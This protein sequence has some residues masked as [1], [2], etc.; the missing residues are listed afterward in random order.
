MDALRLFLFDDRRARRWAPFTLTRPVGE[1]RHGCLRLRERAEKA[2]GVACEGHVTRHALRGFDE[3]G[4]APTVALEE[5]DTDGTRVLL[6]SRVALELGSLEVGD[7][8]RRLTVSG[9]GAGWVVPAGEPPPSELWLRDPSS[10]P[11]EP[12]EEFQLEGTVLDRPWDLIAANPDR[13]ASDVGFLWSSEDDP[14]GVVRIGDG[15]ISL[16]AGATVEPGVHVDTRGG[17]V[18]LDEGVRVEG[19]ARL[20]GPLFVG[21]HSRILG[22]SVGT[23]S[24]GPVCIVRG[25][26]ADSVIDGFVNK[27]HDGYLGHA[28][29]GR[30][31]NLGAYTTNSDLKNNYRP[32]HVWTPDGDIDTESLKVGCFLGDH[33][34][35]GI[36]TVLNT[37]TVVGAGSNVFGGLMPPTV[38]PPFSWG[39]GTDLRDHNLDKFLATAE[40]SMERRGQE[41]TPGARRILA[42]AWQATAGRRARDS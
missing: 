42:E 2:F 15:T 39:S 10:A 29:L 14:P 4:A 18:R 22:G 1:T 16:G 21:A 12:S 24:I 25:E 23:S 41:L 7:R 33:V 5:I 9:E 11:A 32:V 13:I 17:P 36:G 6:S 27:A 38:V 37:G 35:T 20:I 40:R 19:P 34:K 31:V 8:P 30:W 3:P 28:M 26:I